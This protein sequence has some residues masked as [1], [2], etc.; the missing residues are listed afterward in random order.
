MN[1]SCINAKTRKPTRASPRSSNR[2]RINAS[3]MSQLAS[4]DGPANPQVMANTNDIA[5]IGFNFCFSKLIGGQPGCVSKT[6]SSLHM[7]W[8]R[9]MGTY[10]INQTKNNSNNPEVCHSNHGIKFKQIFHVNVTA[11]LLQDFAVIRCKTNCVCTS[12]SLRICSMLS[13][14]LSL[15]QEIMLPQPRA[16]YMNVRSTAC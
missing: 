8:I 3:I 7:V 14:S 12:L 16:A 2:L 15:Q 10:T 13:D 9:A 11:F 1:F 5:K 4:I 6:S